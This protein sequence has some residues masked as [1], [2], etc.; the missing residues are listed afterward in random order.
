[1]VDTFV[2]ARQ[3]PTPTG[4][5]DESTGVIRI[6]EPGWYPD[7]NDPEYNRYWNGRAWT[8]R[9]HPAGAPPPPSTPPRSADPQPTREPHRPAEPKKPKQRLPIW[10]WVIGALF[11]LRSVVSVM[12]A[13]DDPAPGTTTAVPSHPAAVTPSA[14]TVALDPPH[15]GWR[16]SLRRG[17]SATTSDRPDQAAVEGLAGAP[18]LVSAA[19]AH[20]GDTGPMTQQQPYEAIG[21]W[22]EVEIRRYPAHTIAEV[23]VDGDFDDAGNRGFRPLFG[24]IQGRIAMTAP[25]V[26][27]QG[28]DGHSVAFVMPAGRGLDTLPPPTDPRVHVRCR[29]GAGGGRPEV[30]RLGQ[31]GRSRTSAGGS[32]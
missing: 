29:P 19:S 28:E 31:R 22:G 14:G 4:D 21:R 26:Q 16:V 12:A 30:L 20:R 9:R 13:F 25:V 17:H 24:Y 1:M 10:M 5:D 18:G 27:T 32:C 3:S 23:V 8:A 7:R 11:L 2:R 6:A 15:S